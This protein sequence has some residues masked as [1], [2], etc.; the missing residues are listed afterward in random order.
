VKLSP[1]MATAL[2]EWGWGKNQMRYRTHRAL[3]DRGLATPYELTRKGR[4][5]RDALGRV[6][7]DPWGNPDTDPRL[8]PDCDE[9]VPTAL[10]RWG[11]YDGA[12]DAREPTCINCQEAHRE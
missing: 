9:Y 7:T 10:V 5:T 2:R 8:C 1:T 6:P 12:P 3:I 11:D 4:L